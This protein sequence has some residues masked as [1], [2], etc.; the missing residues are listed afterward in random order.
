MPKLL[1][2]ELSYK[3][4]G[5]LMEVYNE[6]GNK[7]QEKY[8]QR[9]VEKGLHNE[10]ISYL[11]ESPVD[12]KFKDE[13][14]GHYKVDFLIED[15]IILEIKARPRLVKS[16]YGQVRSYLR[17]TGLELGILANFG[18]ESLY[19]KRISNRLSSD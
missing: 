9:A 13:K 18:G 14:I 19:F 12:I 6:L 11:R 1:Y 8:Y 7:Y 17:S 3:I 2:P 4:I 10:K 15:Q 5:V 16:D